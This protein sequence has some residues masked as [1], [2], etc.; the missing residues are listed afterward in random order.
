MNLDDLFQIDTKPSKRIKKKL[1][2]DRFK[3][4]I[5]YMENKYEIEKVKAMRIARKRGK[6]L[7]KE[8]VKETVDDLE[9][10]WADNNKKKVKGR[11]RRAAK[12]RGVKALRLPHPG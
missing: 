12:G 2:K 9:D 10:L 8:K 4:K 5:T 3:K 6:V 7:R 1:K 11:K